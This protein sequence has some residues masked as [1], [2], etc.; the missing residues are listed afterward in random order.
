MGLIGLRVAELVGVK[1]NPI[2][3]EYISLAKTRLVDLGS[4]NLV[5]SEYVSLSLFVRVSH[6]ICLCL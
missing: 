4:T 2:A 5:A 6:Y 3:S 1:G